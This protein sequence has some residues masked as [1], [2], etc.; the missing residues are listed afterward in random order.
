MNQE[1]LVKLEKS[2][3][4]LKD[5]TSKIYLI[6]QDTKGNAKASVAYIYNLGMALH[7][8]G[9]NPIILHECFYL[10]WV[11]G[12]VAWG[13]IGITRNELYAYRCQTF[14]SKM[15]VQR[16]R[17]FI[18]GTDIFKKIEKGGKKT[19]LINKNMKQK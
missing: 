19:S 8:A 2:I 4:N 1:N 9:Y 17:T 14:V 10:K 16:A 5:K 7:T 12:N 11:R 13:I 18:N 3:Q 15:S 6:V